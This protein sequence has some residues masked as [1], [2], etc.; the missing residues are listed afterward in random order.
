MLIPGHATAEGTARFRDRFTAKLPGHFREAAYGLWLSS[1]GVGTYLGDPTAAAD[2]LYRE[3]VTHAL[4]K[5]INVIDSAVNYRH[6]HSERAIGQAV[7]ALIS[8]GKVL[9]DELFL[10]TKGGF[11]TFDGEEPADPSAYFQEKLIAP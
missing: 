11:L 5:G 4:E 1:I 7:T 10:A 9:R 2:L 6:Q 8:E 3:A